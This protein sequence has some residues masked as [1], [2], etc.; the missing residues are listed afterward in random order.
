M[1]IAN[2]WVTT[3][4]LGY[5]LGFMGQRVLGQYDLALL[6]AETTPGKLLFVEENIRQTARSCWT[7]RSTRSGP[8]SP[9]TRRPT[10]SSSRRIPG[11]DR[12]SPSV[13]SVSSAPFSNDAAALGRDGLKRLGRSLRGE[14]RRT[15]STG[16][17]G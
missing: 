16:W 11:S 13:S 2:R 8:G 10:P 5:L 6:A 3:R 14:G 4:Q 7:C 15:T 12:I 17:S 1:T 9:S